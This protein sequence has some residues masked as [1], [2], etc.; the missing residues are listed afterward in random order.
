MDTLIPEGMTFVH[1]SLNKHGGMVPVSGGLKP[2]YSCLFYEAAVVLFIHSD[3]G[4]QQVAISLFKG[5]NHC[6]HGVRL[7]PVAAV[8]DSDDVTFC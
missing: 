7:I 3:V 6:F 4:K 1:L 2:S 8:Q 5:I